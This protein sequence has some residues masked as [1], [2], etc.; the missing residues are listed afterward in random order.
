[1]APR[2]RLTCKRFWL[3]FI[4]GCRQVLRLRDRRAAG[5][6]ACSTSARARATYK[7][8]VREQP[9]AFELDGH[10]F[11]ERGKVFPVCGNTWRMLADTRFSPHFGFIGDFSTHYGI[12]P[13]CGT[14]IPFA[15]GGPQE[16]RGSCC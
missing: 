12:F 6:A 13:G 11:I 10:H 14:S 15:A 7:G 2:C 3:M 4:R 16:A 9:D 8:S 1:M 5:A